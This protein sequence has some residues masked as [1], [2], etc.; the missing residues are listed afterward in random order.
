M[1][2]IWSQKYRPALLNDMIGRDDIVAQFM[3]WGDHIA[4]QKFL[5]YSKEAGTGKT[6]IAS[7]LASEYDFQLH[8]FNASTKTERG[9]GCMEEE[10]IPRTRTGNPN[11]IILLY[12]ADN[13]TDAAQYAHK[14]IMA[15][16]QGNFILPSNKLTTV[17][18]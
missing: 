15:N 13:L 17:S 2:E 14:E 3:D 9:I 12:D 4:M 5:F 10:L 11:Q 7:A 16:A 6:T 18:P 1:T 8:V